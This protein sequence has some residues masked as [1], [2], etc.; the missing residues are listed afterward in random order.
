MIKMICIFVTENKHFWIFLG[1]E[2]NFMKY[3]INEI[4]TSG[5]PYDYGIKHKSQ[6]VYFTEN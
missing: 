4:T 2:N 1:Y 5:T 3:T 6:F